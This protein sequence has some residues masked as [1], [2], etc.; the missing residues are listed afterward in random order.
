[1]KSKIILLMFVFSSIAFAQVSSITDISPDG[2]T[3]STYSANLKSSGGFVV[4]T[5]DDVPFATAPQWTAALERQVGGMAWGDYDGD[6]DLDLA[7]GCYFSNS[8][9]P[10]PNYEVMIYKNE[11][12]M[13]GTNPAWISSDMKSTTDVKFADINQD[14]KLDL[15]AANGDNSFVPSVIYMNGAA[16]LSVN[17]SWTSTTGAWTVGAAFADVDG[18]GDL[19]MAFGNQGSSSV[20]AKPITVWFNN[21]GTY[22]SSPNWLSSDQM[23]TNTVAFGDM[24]N[25]SLKNQKYSIVQTM[26]ASAY[27]LPMV[28][29]YRIDTVLVNGVPVSAYCVNRLDGW[30]SLKVKPPVGSQVTIKYRS[31]EKGDLAAS[32][33]VNYE[34]GVY[35]NNNGNLSTTP[36][37]TVGNTSSQKGIAWEDFDRDG[38]QDLAIS[39]SGVQAVIYKNTHG[40]LSGPVWTSNAVNPSVQE[41]ITGDIDGDGY[42]ELAT[43]G[44]GTKRIEVY[45]N[46]NGVLDIAPTWVYVAGTSATAIS[47]GDMNGDG[48]LDLAVGTARSPVEVFLN[49]GVSCKKVDVNEGWNLVG[50]PVSAVS[51]AVAALFPNANSA[52]FSYA[53]GYQ[54]VTQMENGKGYW[55]RFA[56]TDSVQICGTG[57][58]PS[59]VNLAA[60]WNLITVFGSQVEV[61]SIVSSPP[62]IINS[63]FF[64]YLNGYT[65]PSL[66]LPG[67]GYWVRASQQGTLILSGKK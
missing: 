60:G 27:S 10:V 53:N 34:S 30:V 16:G 26:N 38:Y 41:L 36:G 37:W 23:I 7:V 28:P 18:D 9:P 29:V 22:T 25:S 13:L 48:L 52:A 56:S 51:M 35:F 15:L 6:G 20:P 64:G 17:P 63:S 54:Q 39:G 55:L 44:F 1:M 47:F 19:D 66:L 65:T 62:G 5:S 61:S 21:N 31:I 2:K 45:K 11:N 4:K 14:G 50:V 43:V 59:T 67:K 24:D 46:R 32:K 49:Q 42:P 40:A 33:W 8:F 58:T 57:V 3:T 12:G